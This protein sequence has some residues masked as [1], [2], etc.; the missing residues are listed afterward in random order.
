MFPE[1]ARLYTWFFMSNKTGNILTLSVE[2]DDPVL[3]KFHNP[4]ARWSDNT[5]VQ[6]IS[7]TTLL[8]LKDDIL[9]N[10]MVENPEALFD[11]LTLEDNPVLFFY[12]FNPDKVSK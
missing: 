8:A 12:T 10:S 6:D 9:S 1:R 4:L 3:S 11:G 5:L 2:S 7:P